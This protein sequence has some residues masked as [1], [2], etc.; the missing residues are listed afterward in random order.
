MREKSLIRF[1]GAWLKFRPL[2]LHYHYHPGR[3]PLSYLKSKLIEVS[4]TLKCP[5]GHFLNH[6]KRISND[7]SLLDRFAAH[8]G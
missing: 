3:L 7:R 5:G 1:A 4:P 6:S 8:P 2:I